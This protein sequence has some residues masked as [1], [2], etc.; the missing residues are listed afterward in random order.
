MVLPK[1]L[2]TSCLSRMYYIA[3]EITS[4]DDAALMIFPTLL[5]RVLFGP[6]K[7][8]ALLSPKSA[9]MVPVIHNTVT[10]LLPNELY[11]HS[12]AGPRL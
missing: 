2:V 11:I 5:F 1:Y 12:T 3:I 6:Y 4:D 9:S 8:H 10:Q 7:S